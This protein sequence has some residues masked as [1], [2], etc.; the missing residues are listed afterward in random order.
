M[1]AQIIKREI[2]YY[3][4]MM[5]KE[6]DRKWRYAVLDGVSDDCLYSMFGF[7]V[8]EID[9]LLGISYI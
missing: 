6:L 4:V 8:E 7:L 1:N 2:S 9:I 5:F 3:D